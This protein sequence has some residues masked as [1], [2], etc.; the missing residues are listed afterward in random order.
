MANYRGAFECKKCPANND[1]SAGRACPAWWE[2]V[3]TTPQGEMKNQ[4]ACAW[5]Q[6]PHFLIEVIKAS[7]R[8]AAALESTRNEIAVWL[9]RIANAVKSS[10]MM[11]AQ[12]STMRELES[13]QADQRS[14]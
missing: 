4:K 1:P 13:S 3:W 14:E 8:P 12:A 5:V 7:N 2:T 11:L 6:L 9:S 10:P